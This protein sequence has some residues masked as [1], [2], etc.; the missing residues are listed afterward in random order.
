LDTY[1]GCKTTSFGE[2]YTLKT[3]VGK[4][5][6]ISAITIPVLFIALFI[7]AISHEQ[8]GSGC[9]KVTAKE[10][11]SSDRAFKATLLQEVCHGE[12]ISYSVRLD[13]QEKSSDR[14]WF[15]PGFELEGDPYPSDALE[16]PEVNW[17]SERKLEVLVHTRTVSG[18]IARK[19]DDNL[20]FIR[21]YVP[22]GEKR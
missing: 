8:N 21:S 18:S 10:A 9:E 7:F 4:F 22:I 20:I 17:L 15:V 5:I 16:T 19:V 3:P 12:T 6:V 11:W 1:S 2:G 14:A 13:H